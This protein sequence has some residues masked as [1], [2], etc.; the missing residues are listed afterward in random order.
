MTDRKKRSASVS[1]DREETIETIDLS[2]TVVGAFEEACRRY[3]SRTALVYLG[4]SFSYGELWEQMLR[5]AH[6]L[7]DLGVQTGDRVILYL[8]N[9]PQWLIAYFALQKIGAV[10]VPISPIYTPYELRYIAADAEARG[11]FGLD[12]NFG[13]I[14]EVDEQQPF[15]WIVVSNL[16]DLLPGWKRAF[17]YAFDRVPRGR[18]SYDERTYSFRRL[19]R[20]QAG[21]QPREHSPLACLFYTSGTTGRPKGIPAQHGLLL[22]SVS[23]TLQVWKEIREG[24]HKLALVLSLFHIFP[25]TL[26]WIC[27]IAGHPVVLFPKV[28][29]DALFAAIERDRITLFAGVPALYRSILEHDRRDQYD[30]SSLRYCF[31]AGDVLPG[32]VLRRWE[33]RFGIPIYQVYGSTEVDYVAVSPLDRPPTP[34]SVGLPL[35]SREIRIVDP[36]TG[37]SLPPGEVGELWVSTPFVAEGYWN[38]PEE[39]ARSFVSQEGRMWYR[40]GDFM[41]LDADG[42]L[43]FEE[44]RADIIKYKGYRVAAS[45]IEAALQDHP[46]VVEACVIGVPDENVGERI[47]AFVVLKEDARGVGAQDLL[48]WCRQRLAPYKVPSAIEFRDMLP[49]SK[50]GKLLRREM[51]E[52]ERRRLGG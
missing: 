24:Q 31:S 27:L 11:I 35:P 45:E 49:K 18:V 32:E 26:A 51:R 42:Q 28:N 38:K 3:H 1:T 40:M 36:E 2:L 33:R 30:L 7:Q 47:K 43:Y 34:G 44:R 6:G 52:E 41:R 14:R 13:Y 12:T 17:G 16:V 48:R 46:A 29:L 15:K 50:V 20:R 23:D 37:R 8:P 10:P 9:S 4:T 5:C 39:T 22:S 21:V 25:Q 19:L